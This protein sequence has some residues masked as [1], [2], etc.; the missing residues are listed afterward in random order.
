MSSCVRKPNLGF[1]F[2]YHSLSEL[3]KGRGDARNG[4]LR[5]GEWRSVFGSPGELGADAGNDLLFLVGIGSHV[6]DFLLHGL[7][8]LDTGAELNHLLDGHLLGVTDVV[9]HLELSQVTHVVGQ[10]Q[11]EI[12][13]HG[14]IEG[15]HLLGG[16]STAGDGGVNGEFGLGE[17]LVL[18]M[19]F[20]ND[21]GGVDGSLVSSPVDLFTDG[22]GLARVVVVEDGGELTVGLTGMSTVGGC[23]ETSKPVSSQFVG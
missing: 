10:V 8:A 17:T 6:T 5:V 2:C 4:I 12:P 14:D 3:T 13:L 7:H 15:L 16:S 9:H 19:E 22:G 1:S 11:L 18:G 21:V 20:V 23:A